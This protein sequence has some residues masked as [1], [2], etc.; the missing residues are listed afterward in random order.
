MTLDLY[1]WLSS[2]IHSG[3]HRHDVRYKEEQAQELKYTRCR[4]VHFKFTLHVQ[5]ERL[6]TELNGGKAKTQAAHHF[7][8]PEY[9]NQHK[10][11]I[12]LESRAT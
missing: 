10:N 1:K 12:T 11:H 2:S 9:T 3:T 4:R 5:V 8:E 7:E 6:A